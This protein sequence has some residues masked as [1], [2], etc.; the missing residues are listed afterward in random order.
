MVLMGLKAVKETMPIL[1]PGNRKGFSLLEIIVVVVLLAAASA[2]VLPS[3]S[4]TF[5]GLQV[6]TAG[7]DMATVMKQARS[8]AVGRQQPYRV[9]P[10][11]SEFSGEALEYTLADEYGRPVKVFPLPDGV[12]FVGAEGFGGPVPG[13]VSFYPSGRSSGAV[14]YLRNEQ[15]KTVRV[16]VDPVTGFSVVDTL[17]ESE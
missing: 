9:M 14:F 16:A 13:G 3:F 6:E 5:A 17:R 12:R 2:I 10:S 15:G 4:G 1:Y 8:Y 7:R 11:M